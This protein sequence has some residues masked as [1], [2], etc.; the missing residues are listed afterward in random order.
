MDDD[1]GYPYDLSETP[2]PKMGLSEQ[3]GD[4]QNHE[5]IG[6]SVRH[7]ARSGCSGDSVGR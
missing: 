1:W 3:M 4:P 2:T 7:L 5:V 6:R